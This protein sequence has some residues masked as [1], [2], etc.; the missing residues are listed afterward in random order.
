MK[1]IENASSF[2]PH[3]VKCNDDYHKSN[4]CPKFGAGTQENVQ[5]NPSVPYVNPIIQ[6]PHLR[7]ECAPFVTVI[8]GKIGYVREMLVQK[9]HDTDL[10]LRHIFV[11]P[12]T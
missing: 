11:I 5:S 3:L 6:P 12:R 2:Y 1:V 8:P 10:W 7:E 4:E 9:A